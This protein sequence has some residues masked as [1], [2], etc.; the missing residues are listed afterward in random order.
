MS[1]YLAGMIA[2]SEHT[3]M[4]QSRQP[5]LDFDRRGYVNKPGA[6]ARS[7]GMLFQ[8]LNSILASLQARVRHEEQQT[9]TR[10]M[11][12]SNRG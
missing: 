6:F 8:G 2:H 10:E 11:P 7:I 5:V 9:I 3:Q 1:N 4:N 12:L